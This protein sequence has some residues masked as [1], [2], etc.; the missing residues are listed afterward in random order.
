MFN[1][2]PENGG[3]WVCECGGEEHPQQRSLKMV[4]LSWHRRCDG[5]TGRGGA[6]PPWLCREAKL[7]LWK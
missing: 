1:K 3:E 6:V 7:F 5:G 2:G 4:A